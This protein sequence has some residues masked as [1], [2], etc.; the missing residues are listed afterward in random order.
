M[1][2]WAWLSLPF[3]S[4][5]AICFH[6]LSFSPET[7]V[8]FRCRRVMFGRSLQMVFSVSDPRRCYAALQIADRRFPKHVL[9]SWTVSLGLACVAALVLS[10]PPLV[11]VLPTAC[12]PAMHHAPY[13]NRTV[14][15][16]VRSRTDAPSA[17]SHVFA[18]TTHHY[19][20]TFI[21]SSSPPSLPLPLPLDHDLLPARSIVTLL[22]TRIPPYTPATYPTNPTCTIYS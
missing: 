8:L 6:G 3:P 16:A 14:C 1:L 12:A 10:Q 4:I 19:H 21:A 13:S 9:T 20:S 18:D 22:P 2:A 7:M 17:R 15:L 5:C 11:A